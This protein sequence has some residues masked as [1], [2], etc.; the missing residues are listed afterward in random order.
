MLYRVTQYPNVNT[1]RSNKA[2]KKYATKSLVLL[3][4]QKFSELS[5]NLQ[6]TK[7]TQKKDVSGTFWKVLTKK[8][9]FRRSFSLTISILSTLKEVRF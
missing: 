9:L 4:N 1:R 3:D 6:L 8:L 2:E 7:K 5:Q